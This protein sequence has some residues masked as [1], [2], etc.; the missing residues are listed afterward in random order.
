MSLVSRLGRGGWVLVLAAVLSCTGCAYMQNRG[1]DL[2]QVINVGVTTSETPQIA[3]Y[4]NLF[5]VVALGYADFDGK[6]YGFVNEHW[7]SY[8]ARHHG[9]GLLL[10]GTERFGW[11][12]RYNP[13][14]PESPPSWRVGP[15]GWATGPWPPKQETVNS[16]KILH[17]GWVGLSAYCRPGEMA[18]FLLGWF[19]LDIM[20]DDMAR[21]EKAGAEPPPA[22]A[23]EPPP[24]K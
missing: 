23:V 13:K 19:G 5:S 12:D 14:D 21:K 2:A 11:G 15:I 8:D 22:K 3:V 17:L 20:N 16:P 18:D 7:G 1:N 6:M 10:W 4:F 24:A 9:T